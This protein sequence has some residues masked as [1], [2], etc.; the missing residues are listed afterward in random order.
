MSILAQFITKLQSFSFFHSSKSIPDSEN[1]SNPTQPSN[2][3]PSE[4]T[5]PSKP[6]SQDA[7]P[8]LDDMPNNLVITLPITSETSD[9]ETPEQ[10]DKNE[11]DSKE[12]EGTREDLDT[13]GPRMRDNSGSEMDLDRPPIFRT[14]KE[15]DCWTMFQKMTKKGI[16]VSYDTIL[17]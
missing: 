1:S 3:M 10:L 12:T 6:V 11:T 14:S 4:T 13:N 7:K 8:D 15:Q 5:L 9:S 17:R 2:E 16:N